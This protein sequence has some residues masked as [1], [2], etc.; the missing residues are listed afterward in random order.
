MTNVAVGGNTVRQVTDVGGMVKKTA[1][2]AGWDVCTAECSLREMERNR[3][4]LKL[5]NLRPDLFKK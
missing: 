5:S 3:N 4:G 2:R 1:R